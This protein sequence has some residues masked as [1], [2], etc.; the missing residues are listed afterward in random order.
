[1][2]DGHTKRIYTHG[3]FALKKKE[4]RPQPTTQMQ[5]A[6]VT[7]RERSQMLKDRS[8]VIPLI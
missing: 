4:I 5:V 6:N 3:A 2:G 7:L 8:H 1:M